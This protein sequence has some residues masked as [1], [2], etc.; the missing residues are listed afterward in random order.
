MFFNKIQRHCLALFIH[1][2]HLRSQIGRF[3][4][5]NKENEI[6][7]NVYDIVSTFYDLPLVLNPASHSVRNR[8]LVLIETFRKTNM[9]GYKYL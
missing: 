2:I 4:F 6:P 1:V 5:Q 7:V 9:Y 3:T 8:L